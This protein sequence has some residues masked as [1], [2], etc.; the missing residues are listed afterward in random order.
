MPD[1]ELMFRPVTALAAMV[2]SGEIS[3]REL[4]EVSLRR[5]DELNGKLN[6]FVDVDTE[7]ALATAEGVGQGDARPFAGV[8]IAIKNNRAVKGMRLTY[9]C[10]LMAKHVADYDH[11]VVRRLKEA[12]FIVVGTT[13]LPEYGIL[14]VSEARLF[15]PTPHRRPTSSG[16][17]YAASVPG[18]TSA[19]P[20]GLQASEAIFATI[21]PLATPALTVRPTSAFTR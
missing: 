11:N 13:T 21:F 10:E 8:P 18:S 20:S 3:A 1:G 4:V 17:K 16:A 5:I 2:R 14:P 12:G 6:A 15:G 19:K 7:G 9:G